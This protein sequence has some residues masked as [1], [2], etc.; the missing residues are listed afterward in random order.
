MK[1]KYI[2]KIV[3]SNASCT[4]NLFLLGNFSVG[5][6]SLLNKF[7]KNTFTEFYLPT[8]GFDR[9]T[10]IITLAKDKNIKISF[11]DTAGQERYRSI[12][13][14]LIKY[15]DGA[16][17]VFDITKKETFNAIPKWIESVREHKGNDY[18]ITLIGN[19]LDLKEEREVEAVEGKKL[20]E[21]YGFSFF[22]TSSKE[23]TNVHESILELALKILVQKEKEEKL[24]EEI[25]K[26]KDN[27]NKKEQKKVI[28]LKKEKKPRKKTNCKC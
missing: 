23:G 9:S 28:K 4:I 27:G 3:E 26:E 18:P 25:E 7:V 6:T 16:I 15:S 1:I 8:I 20:A 21:K 19:K 2:N 13:S 12:A 10:K 11:Y 24:E 17:L 14:N 22:E 5:K